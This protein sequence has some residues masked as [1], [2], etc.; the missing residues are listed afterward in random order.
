LL[1]LRRDSTTKKKGHPAGG[2][3]VGC[4]DRK[5]TNLGPLFHSKGWVQHKKTLVRGVSLKKKAFNAMLSEEAFRIH[6]ALIG[7]MYLFCF[8]HPFGL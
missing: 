1:S 2:L 6:R 3:W 7:C 8:Y 4:I 5:E